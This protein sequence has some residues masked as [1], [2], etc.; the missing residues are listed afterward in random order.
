MMV[1]VRVITGGYKSIVAGRTGFGIG[2]QLRREVSYYYR[3]IILIYMTT[4][5]RVRMQNGNVPGC[6]YILQNLLL[7]SIYS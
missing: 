1:V 3:K 7:F 4:Y 2:N 5:A 6:P